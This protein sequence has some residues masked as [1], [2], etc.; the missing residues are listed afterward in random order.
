MGCGT[1]PRAPWTIDLH[2]NTPTA[3]SHV[4]KDCCKAQAAAKDRKYRETVEGQRHRWLTVGFETFGAW[5]DGPQQL[6]TKLAAVSN[7]AL[8]KEDI[9]Q[10]IAVVLQAS[11]A[12]ILN[13]TLALD[14]LADRRG[15]II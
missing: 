7:G 8:T 9:V 12:A 15:V 1:A 6:A 2:V 13:S 3:A 4:G 10:T 14:R 5:R 11:N